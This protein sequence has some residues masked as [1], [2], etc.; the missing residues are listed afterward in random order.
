MRPSGA[1]WISALLVAAT[2]GV[3]LWAW[4]ALPPG[5]G[6][7]THYLGLDGHRHAG[8]SRAAL[9]VIPFVSAI[10]TLGLT[11]GP[12]FTGRAVEAYA[13][14]LYAMI[15]IS[16]TGLLLVTESTL[17]ARAF[18]ADYNVMRPVAMATGVL[19]LAVGN[20][21]GKARQNAVVGIKTPWTLSDPRVWDKTHRFTGRAMFLGGLALIAL[22]F[23]LHDGNLLGAAIAACTA[24][25]VL[26][27]AVWSR[28]LHGQAA[29]TV[30]RR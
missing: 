29:G 23:A 8:V 7:P 24:L 19:L 10:V 18:D 12:R 25:P 11:F 5:A 3:A 4:L 15:L 21:L 17:V 16:V 14:E 20:Y 13:P 9:W 28:V 22:G 27:G 1:F 26:A 6:V 30:L 2:L